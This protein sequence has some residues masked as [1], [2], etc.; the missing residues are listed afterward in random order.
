M[1]NIVK[2]KFAGLLRGLLRRFDDSDARTAAPPRP[3]AAAAPVRAMPPAAAPQVKPQ[4]VRT[5]PPAAPAASLGDLQLP[6]SSII[7]VLPMDLREKMLMQT[8]PANAS[9]SIPVEKALSQLTHGSVKI[10]FG[11]LCAALPGLF[12][13]S[14][15]NDARQIVLPLNEIIS[16]INPALLSRRATKKIEVTDDI[17]SPFSART[18]GAGFAPAQAPAKAAPMTPP[19]APEPAR[20][21]PT[22]SP[23]A[24]PAAVIPKTMASA[25]RPAPAV[26][27]PPAP[28]PFSPAPAIPA[29]SLGDLK[30]P[31]SSIIPVLPMD[32]RE[33]MLVQTPPASASVSIPVEKALSQLARG[34]VKISF[35]ELCAAL[36]GL[37]DRSGGNDA[38]LIVL[39]LNEIIS[40]INPALLSRR[41]AK[42]NEVTDDIASPFSARTPG[43]GF[44]PAQAPA[45]AAPPI[46]AEISI[47]APLSALVEKWPDA[48]KMELVQ[49]NMMSAQ[50]ALPASLVEPGLKRGRVTVPWKNLRMMIRP[51]P[52]PVSVHDGVELELPINVLAPLFFASQ[53]AAG[54]A[55]QKV[56]VS[57]EIPNLFQASKKTEAAIPPALAPVPVPTPAAT[58]PAKP[59]VPDVFSKAR[60]SRDAVSEPEASGSDFKPP[61][62]T[63]REIVARALALPGVAGAVIAL[64]DGLK[65]AS[66]VPPDFNADTAAAFL[67][68]IFDRVAHCT[69][70]LRMGALNKLE[71]PV[72]NVSWHIFRVN[73]IYFAAFGHA[74]KT[75]PTAQLASLAG[76]L[77]RKKE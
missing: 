75:L 73:A 9:V 20:A 33:K 6:L 30:L 67:P 38:R 49:A 22:P 18:P 13:H 24:P 7:P 40:R 55:K 1:S 45:K 48:I 4:P 2:S 66:E 28:I 12:D 64:Y 51:N 26:V 41:A 19:R 29:A 32:L 58:F 8:P 23:V 37:F 56:S 3:V 31:L 54:L 43:A 47:F 50:A 68:Q 42:K 25:T 39:P 65:I 70:E 21:S 77:D 59:D 44:A 52:P 10:S 71:F 35:G 60:T 14:G 15:E 11:E 76:E 16:R 5:P 57:A 63:P 34:S 61:G 46:A 69:R 53:K 72:G 74:G 36:P 27:V 17:A 62:A